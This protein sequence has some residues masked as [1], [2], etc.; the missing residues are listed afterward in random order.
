MRG[1]ASRLSCSPLG[2]EAGGA[3]GR[4]IP[5]VREEEGLNLLFLGWFRA[6]RQWRALCPIPGMEPQETD[7]GPATIMVVDDDRDLLWLLCRHLGKAGLAVECHAHAPSAALVEQVRPAVLFLD[8]EIGQ[9]NGEEVCGRI[10]ASPVGPDVPV[11]LISSL[12]QDSLRAAAERCGA[13]GYLA[14][15][16]DMQGMTRLAKQ[17]VDARARH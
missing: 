17:Y 16:F 2:S 8:V 15:P 11:I 12:P 7:Q 3:P 1:H 5:V 13:N 14:K 6:C 9:E 10:K 4:N